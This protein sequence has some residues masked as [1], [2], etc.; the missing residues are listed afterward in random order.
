MERRGDN[1]A[2]EGLVWRGPETSRWG[3]LRRARRDN[4]GMREILL[5]DR[6]PERSRGGSG[7]AGPAR[8]GG[9]VVPGGLP[10]GDGSTP[11]LYPL[12]G[13]FVCPFC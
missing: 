4:A 2:S 8:P 1:G 13:R 11:P 10:G 12:E 5:D 9:P 7:A 3:W 6:G